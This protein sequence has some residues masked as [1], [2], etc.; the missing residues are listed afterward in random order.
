[1]KKKVLAIFLAMMVTLCATMP[2]YAVEVP[3]FMSEVDYYAVAE[4]T[5]PFLTICAA[6]PDSGLTISADE[7]YLGQKINLYY[8]QND[9]LVPSEFAYFPIIQSDKIIAFSACMLDNGECIS[10]TTDRVNEVNQYVEQGV[11]DF[12]IVYDERVAYACSEDGV[13]L[14]D[15]WYDGENASNTIETFKEGVSFSR[16][17]SKVKLSQISV[18][19]NDIITYGTNSTV[20]DLAVPPK[21]QLP[22]EYIC[23]AACVASVGQQRT[24]INYTAQQVADKVNRSN[25]GASANDIATYLGDLYSINATSQAIPSGTEILGDLKAN[26]PLIF[27]MINSTYTG[28][29]GIVICGFS[30]SPSLGAYRYMD[31]WGG[32]FSWI[33][34][35]NEGVYTITFCGQLLTAGAAVRIN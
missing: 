30:A 21:N 2:A 5:L 35:V 27:S 3:T 17:A 9:K 15:V 4:E 29:H 6:T 26:K 25:S 33:R 12:A 19:S 8:T 13:Q 34:L 31:P 10:I 23:W 11:K 1:M 14:L 18:A 22:N 7:I 32:T 20:Y 28:G 24:G 16:V